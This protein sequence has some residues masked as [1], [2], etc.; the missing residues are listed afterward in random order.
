MTDITS[1]SLD[2][3]HK[4]A[5]K[6]IRVHVH[7]PDGAAGKKDFLINPADRE[8]HKNDKTPAQEFT[9]VAGCLNLRNDD[10]YDT[11]N[12]DKEILYGDFEAGTVVSKDYDASTGLNDAESNMNGVEGDSFTEAST[13]LAKHKAGTRGYAAYVD[14]EGHDLRK[15]A[16]YYT[17]ADIAPD[18]D[19]QGDY[20]GGYP[21]AKTASSATPAERI[22][23]T[24]LTIWLEGWDHA[25]ID[26]N[27]A[28]YF[29]LG[30]TF[31]INRV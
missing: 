20:S 5:D 21:V 11:D 23:R 18:V 19:G 22:A 7:N 17:L 4:N 3:E 29:N 25:I 31:E 6:A 16:F 26:A 13:F 28:T 14:A 24:D 1:S 8:E 15:K 12:T 9:Y 30:L 2:P 27:V 10:F